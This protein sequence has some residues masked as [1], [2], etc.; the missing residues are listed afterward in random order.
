MYNLSKRVYKLKCKNLNLHM[1]DNYEQ[2]D[3]KHCK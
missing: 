2:I 1:K 3:I